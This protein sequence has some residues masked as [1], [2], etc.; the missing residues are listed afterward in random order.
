MPLAAVAD[1]GLCNFVWK[2]SFVFYVQTMGSTWE[3]NVKIIDCKWVLSDY[4]QNA[5]IIGMYNNLNA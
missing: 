3:G 2:E 1:F 5:S 4:G